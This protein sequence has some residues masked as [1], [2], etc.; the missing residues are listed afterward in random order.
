LRPIPTGTRE[1]NGETNDDL[2]VEWVGY[3][4]KA[5]K[6]ER[7]ELPQPALEALRAWPPRQGRE[8]G[9]M[10][11]DDSLWPSL[12]NGRGITSGT[13]YGNLRRYLKK[14]GLPLSGCTSSGI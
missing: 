5:G 7:R 6:S 12:A 11:A 8:F 1:R 13:F 2:H 14:A 9:T 10:S 3:K 4:G